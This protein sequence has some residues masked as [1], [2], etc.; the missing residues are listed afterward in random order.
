MVRLRTDSARLFTVSAH[1]GL[2][3]AKSPFFV[4]F[5]GRALVHTGFCKLKEKMKENY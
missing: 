3:L 5:A 2:S 1:Y 4:I